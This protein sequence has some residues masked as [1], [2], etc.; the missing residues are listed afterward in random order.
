MTTAIKTEVEEYKIYV[1]CLAS[2][3]N[4]CL[5][6]KWIDATQG[7]EEVKEEI[8]KMLKAS[9]EF[10]AEEFAIH[11]FDLGGCR[12]DEYENIDEVCELAEA[13]EESDNPEILADL[14]NEF[15]LE[16]A[17]D[18]IENESVGEYESYEEYGIS[19]TQDQWDLPTHYEYY[20]DYEKY[21]EEM[22]MDYHVV[23][24]E[25]HN[26]HFFINN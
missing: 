2:Y 17:V 25:N 11:D 21:G 4:G 1:A 6:G 23:E 18:M 5:H 7:A 16:T 15:G 24:D 9:P 20:F 22:A 12:I 10:G 8:N 14:Y 26:L 3:N 13:L 19:L